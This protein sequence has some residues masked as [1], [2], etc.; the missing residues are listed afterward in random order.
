MVPNLNQKTIV[1]VTLYEIN[2][3]PS[4]WIWYAENFGF[5]I[6]FFMV[7]S[8]LIK[9]HFERQLHLK[10]KILSLKAPITTAADDN[11]FD[12]FPNLKIK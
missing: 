8:K 12:I 5:S 6:L 2:L 10:I 3:I 1:K 11:I 7:E 9:Y 4:G